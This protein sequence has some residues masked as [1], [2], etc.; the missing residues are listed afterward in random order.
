MFT[1]NS[2][3]LILLFNR[4]TF[5]YFSETVIAVSL[6]VAVIDS[7]RENFNRDCGSVGVSVEF[8][9]VLPSVLTPFSWAWIFFWVQ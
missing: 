7:S 6:S 2:R 3:S 1:I 4:K 9:S 8:I 5:T